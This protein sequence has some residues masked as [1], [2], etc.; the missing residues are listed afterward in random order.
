MSSNGLKFLIFLRDAPSEENKSRWLPTKETVSLINWIQ[1]HY[2]TPAMCDMKKE[3]TL[4]GSYVI[5][6]EDR[7]PT[8]WLVE[9]ILQEK[10]CMSKVVY[11]PNAN[12]DW[13]PSFIAYV[14][15]TS[16]VK[17][18]CEAILKE[19]YKKSLPI[20][21]QIEVSTC[22]R[23]R[24]K[25]EEVLELNKT[26]GSGLKSDGTVEHVRETF[27]FF[28]RFTHVYYWHV[29]NQ[30]IGQYY[31]HRYVLAYQKLAIASMD[32]FGAFHPAVLD[33]FQHVSSQSFFSE[34][35][36]SITVEDQTLEWAMEKTAA[37]KPALGSPI[38]LFNVNTKTPRAKLNQNPMCLR[39]IYM[40][41]PNPKEQEYDCEVT[42]VGFY[43]DLSYGEKPKDI[44]LK[45]IDKF[46]SIKHPIVFYGSPEICKIVK[47][48]RN[49]SMTKIIEKDITELS[50]IRDFRA[51]FDEADTNL[52]FNK[53]KRYSL[54][55][56]LK[57]A[58][59]AEA[60][61]MNYFGSKRFIM[62]DTGIFKHPHISSEMKLNAPTMTT[63]REVPGKITMFSVAS[64][65]SS[66]EEQMMSGYEAILGW[67]IGADRETIME[68]SKLYYEFIYPL[69]KKDVFRTEQ[70]YMTRHAT[71]HPLKYHLLFGNYTLV[72]PENIDWTAG[73]LKKEVENKMLTDQLSS[74]SS[75]SG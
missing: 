54:L 74:S 32:R 25:I 59:L 8:P 20:D 1:F 50:L 62:M 61:E 4:A 75:S 36:K 56:N 46:C 19:L 69:M 6:T 70:V 40:V 24:D 64:L 65:A 72:I 27:D 42:I 22:D 58:I 68:Y 47:S 12:D 30:V 45:S 7:Y 10:Q 3:I 15:F 5:I 31:G 34:S 41:Y 28:L 48:K 13:L 55:T 38:I 11:H 26:M 63:F 71:L 33:L 21:E 52:P 35:N 60:A 9:R 73:A 43:Y 37:A 39:G 53:R 16:E 29:S 18:N 17:G 44:Y 67:F 57:P 23:K 66:T 2:I 51:Q 49:P 14:K